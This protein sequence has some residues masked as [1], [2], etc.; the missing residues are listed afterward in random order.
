M[1]SI[2][3]ITD[4]QIRGEMTPDFSEFKRKEYVLLFVYDDFKS[5][6]C[7]R[8]Y[9]SKHGKNLG[10]ARTHLDGYVLKYFDKSEYP[11]VFAETNM[12]SMKKGYIWGEVWAV[13]PEVILIF[14]KMYQNGIYYNRVKRSFLLTE[15]DEVLKSKAKPFSQAYMYIGNPS[16]WTDDDLVI[17]FGTTTVRGTDQKKVRF[18]E[19]KD[20]KSTWNSYMDDMFDYG[21]GHNY[22]RSMYGS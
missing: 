12:S 4:L 21:H 15:Q 1:R 13:P 2:E 20:K 3:I 11:I 17:D 10:K 19:H 5:D 14:D 16:K 18:Y 6:T 9:L 7:P 22:H 8:K